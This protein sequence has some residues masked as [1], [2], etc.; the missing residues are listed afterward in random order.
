[1]ATCRQSLPL[2]W[3]RSVVEARSSRYRA[4]RI[5]AVREIVCPNFV[6]CSAVVLF[7]HRTINPHSGGNDLDRL[8]HAREFFAY[9]IGLPCL[10]SVNNT[11][12][13]APEAEFI[14][15]RRKAPL[16][17]VGFTITFST[18]R[19]QLCDTVRSAYIP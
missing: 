6:K 15:W 19:W 7:V 4:E 2:R 3:R 16:T 9:L 14:T 8:W 18:E 17:S 10:T 1:M 11:V 12:A 5:A 13:A